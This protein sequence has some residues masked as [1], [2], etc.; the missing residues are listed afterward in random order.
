MPIPV[1][2]N[3]KKHHHKAK[4][5]YAIQSKR[6]IFDLPA[7]T[8]QDDEESQDDRITAFENWLDEVQNTGDW[9]ENQYHQ[10]PE[11]MLVM[12]EGEPDTG[13]DYCYD[14]GDYYQDNQ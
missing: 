14:E 5:P 4:S 3:Q 6:S 8:P 7:L 12:D 11:R 9:L 13:D 10:E 2:R 1:K